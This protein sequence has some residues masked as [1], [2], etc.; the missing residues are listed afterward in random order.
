MEKYAKSYSLLALAL[1]VTWVPDSSLALERE[2]SEIRILALD[3]KRGVVSKVT[4]TRSD[5]TKK[6]L[7][8]TGSNGVKT[9]LQIE[10]C[11]AGMVLKVVPQSG[12]YKIAKKNVECADP[13]VV[14]LERYN[15]EL[16]SRETY[17][18]LQNI[19]NLAATNDP[20][21]EALL[22]SDL[23][24]QVASDD[25]NLSQ[26]YYQRAEYAWAIATGFS[27][28]IAGLD[29]GRIPEFTNHLMQ[30]Q[31]SMGLEPTGIPNYQTFATAA[32]RDIGSF[33]HA[34]YAD[35]GDVPRRSEPACERLTSSVFITGGE[36]LL[37][38][39]LVRAAE[40]R[41]SARE[42]GNAALLFN[43][44]HAR[45]DGD[46]T[47]SVY[48]EHRVYENAGRAL[49]VPVPVLCDPIQRRFVMSAAMVEAVRA[50]QQEVPTG[51]LDYQTLRSLAD[52][53]V[54]SFLARQTN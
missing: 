27:G 48:T 3:N 36:S 33:R 11:D 54:G 45:V 12:W 18:L 6:E 20:A 49:N 25:Q 47:M 44:A 2:L 40:E 8:V 23:S 30:Y 53:D 50:H 38:T 9:L 51:I 7:G 14:Y 28:E 29:G 1:I 35:P 24:G 43:E 37:V 26:D 13:E 46:T 15:F 31:Q 4:L 19:D 41:E 17:N 39:A 52:I 32:D 10:P 5:G 22:Y 34:V 42:Y 21:L 16:A